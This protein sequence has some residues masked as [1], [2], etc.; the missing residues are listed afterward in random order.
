MAGDGGIRCWTG[1]CIGDRDPT[2][3]AVPDDATDTE[4]DATADEGTLI[5]TGKRFSVP[6][7]LR[8]VRPRERAGGN[9]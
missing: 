8:G 1:S 4:A 7:G 5:L 6:G 9:W 3:D 2:G